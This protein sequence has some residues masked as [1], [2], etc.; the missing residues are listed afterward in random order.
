MTT[1]WKKIIYVDTKLSDNIRK[2]VGE[3][4]AAIPL[5]W[6]T[7]ALKCQPLMRQTEGRG[8]HA[9]GSKTEL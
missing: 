3:L 4:L 2:R 6:T 7:L 1:S 9:K 8:N 5:T